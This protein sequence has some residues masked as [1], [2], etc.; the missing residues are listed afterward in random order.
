M[1]RS[2]VPISLYAHSRPRLGKS[3]QRVEADY[4]KQGIKNFTVLDI[5]GYSH[6]DRTS[7]ITHCY[8]QV[9]M[10]YD[11]VLRV[12]WVEAKRTEPGIRSYQQFEVETAMLSAGMESVKSAL[13]PEY[14]DSH[15][16]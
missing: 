15:T 1:Y 2:P 6:Q 7:Y 14:R 5:R 11:S 3:S 16:M 13:M 8:G 12:N 10:R 9:Y 4:E